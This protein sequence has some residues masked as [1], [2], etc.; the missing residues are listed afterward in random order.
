MTVVPVDQAPTLATIT[1]PAAFTE[2]VNSP[3]VV[4][5]IPA[6]INLTNITAGTGDSQN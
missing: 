6:A 5:P 4:P 3:T 2:F 1:N